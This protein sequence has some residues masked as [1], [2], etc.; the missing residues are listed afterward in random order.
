MQ[1]MKK[2]QP[3]AL[4]LEDDVKKVDGRNIAYFDFIA[5][6]LDTKIYNYMF[7]AELEGK[8]LMCS[9]N[10]T[11]AEMKDWKLVARGIMETF[12]MV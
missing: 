7:L 11:E 6:A 10:C 1:I 3:L 12:K 4:W 5:D 2:M 9:F 8:A